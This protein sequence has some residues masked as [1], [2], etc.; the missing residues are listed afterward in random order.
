MLASG[1][2]IPEPKSEDGY[3]GKFVVR[4]PKTLHRLLSEQSKREGLSLNQYVASALAFM[5]GM[6]Q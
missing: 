5:A 4:I 6:K 1:R 2:N 3:S